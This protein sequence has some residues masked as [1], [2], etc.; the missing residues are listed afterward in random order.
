MSELPKGWFEAT[1]G[2]LSQDISYGFTTSASST[3]NGPKFL[4]ITDIQ[5][6]TVDWKAVP[7]CKV[8]Q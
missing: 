4:R 7:F 3:P 8:R 6:G 1:V 5:N 2:I